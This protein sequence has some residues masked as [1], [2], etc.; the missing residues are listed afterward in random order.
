MK[1]ILTYTD[2]TDT[3]GEQHTYN[4]IN[5]AIE[6][7]KLDYEILDRTCHFNEDTWCNWTLEMKL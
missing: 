7:I 3:V 1:Y 5:D 4:N 2:D 6:R